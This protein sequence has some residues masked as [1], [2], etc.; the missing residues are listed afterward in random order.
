MI[1]IAKEKTIKAETVRRKLSLNDFIEKK[2]L[3]VSIM[4][5][6]ISFSYASIMSFISTFAASKNL[7]SYA[8]LFFV[9]FAISMMSLRPFTGKIYDR[10]GASYVIYPAISLFAIGLITLSQVENVTGLMLAA[11]FIGMGFG[12][13]QPCL[14]TISIQRSP[15]D[16]IG[17]ATSTFFTFYDLGIAI[18]SIALGYIIASQG[19]TLT[20]ILCAV[21]T[22]LSLIFYKFCVAQP[23]AKI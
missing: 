9:V 1:P 14:Q 5:M 17:H 18:G 7:L 21:T 13:A 10:K 12:S 22:L 16:R 6:M 11:V 20:Y 4:A 19:Y 8:S 3:P 23:K 15:K 2:A